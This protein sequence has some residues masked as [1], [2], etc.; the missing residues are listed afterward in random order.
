MLDGEP[1]RLVGQALEGT[2]RERRGAGAI[3]AERADVLQPIEQLADIARRRRLRR[4]PE[5]PQ[6]GELAGRPR[7]QQPIEP[8]ERGL[9]QAVGQ[10]AVRERLRALASAADHGFEHQRRRQQH[11]PPAQLLDENAG[12][13]AGPHDR[14]RSRGEKADHLVRDRTREGGIAACR[15]QLGQVLAP[16]GVAYRVVVERSRRNAELAGD[17]GQHRVGRHLTG[18]QHAAWAA[19][20]EEHERVA[21]PGGV[22]SPE[23]TSQRVLAGQREWRAIS[24]SS[25]GG[26]SCR[27]H[28]SSPS[29]RRRAI[30][31]LPRFQGE[32]MS[33]A[34]ASGVPIDRPC[35]FLWRL[36]SILSGNAA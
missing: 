29:R 1:R 20:V 30:A 35:S 2:G 11:A 21:E 36:A 31:Y 14:L 8:G 22:G 33:G 26:S 9:V 10:H 19:Q 4:V 25:A 18:F 3:D 12:E 27:A 6:P 34:A 24:R 23:A 32:P 16:G 15:H 7:R 17:V 28:R 5:P 13:L